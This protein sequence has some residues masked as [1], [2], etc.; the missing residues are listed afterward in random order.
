MSFSFTRFAT[1]ILICLQWKQSFQ[2]MNYVRC[3]LSRI[4]W[5]S[6]VFKMNTNIIDRWPNF[7]ASKLSTNIYMIDF[8][9]HDFVS[10]FRFSLARFLG[11]MRSA[12]SYISMLCRQVKWNNDRSKRFATL[13]LIPLSP[14]RPK[15][16]AEAGVNLTIT[17]F[18]LIWSSRC[19]MSISSILL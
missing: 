11:R 2:I 17:T 1:M 8:D 3:L 13:I 19:S 9:R 6:F 7:L 16:I 18:R 4:Q 15:I 14:P 12:F 5:H 10:I